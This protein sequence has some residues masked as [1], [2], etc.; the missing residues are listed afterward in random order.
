MSD[1]SYKLDLTKVFKNQ[2]YIIRVSPDVQ[3]EGGSTDLPTHIK[4]VGKAI[5][6]KQKGHHKL[7]MRKV[8]MLEKGT[9]NIAKNQAKSLKELKEKFTELQLY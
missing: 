1:Y 6:T 9:R 5:Q 2:R 3:K 4:N 7:M 8:Q